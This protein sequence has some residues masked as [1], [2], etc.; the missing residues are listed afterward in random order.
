M[1]TIEIAIPKDIRE[2]RVSDLIEEACSNEGLTRR[3][4]GG[5]AS[6]PGSTHWH[7]KRGRERGTLEITWL[8]TERRLWFQVQSGRTGDWIESAAARIKSAIED[9]KV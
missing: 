8:P 4:K 9:A 5:L 3:L 1:L 6:L 2:D 7:F